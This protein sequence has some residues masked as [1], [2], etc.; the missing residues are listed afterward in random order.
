M[1]CFIFVLF[2]VTHAKPAYS[3]LSR[4]QLKLGQYLLTGKVT[5]VEKLILPQT[6]TY[7]HALLIW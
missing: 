1:R 6:S 7:I 4:K 5:G 3:F 2:G